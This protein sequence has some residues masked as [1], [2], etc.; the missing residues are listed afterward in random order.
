M[1]ARRVIAS[2]PVIR[3]CQRKRGG[4]KRGLSFER[5]PPTRTRTE[6]HSHISFLNYLAVS[7]RERSLLL[8]KHGT[9]PP[10]HACVCLHQAFEVHSYWGQYVALVQTVGEMAGDLPRT[11]WLCVPC[12]HAL[13]HHTA[14][15][16]T[17]MS[18]STR[19]HCCCP[20]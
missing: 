3:S 15:I 19:P 12:R 13:H 1:R 17:P 14:T 18:V 6:S 2:R 8:L 5:E 20:W 16:T 4:K 10:S 9:R 11:R 7:W